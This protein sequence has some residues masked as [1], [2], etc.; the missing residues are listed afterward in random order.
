[1]TVD[2]KPLEHPWPFPITHEASGAVP[3]PLSTPWPACQA[4]GHR[5]WGSKD[6]HT[7]AMSLELS[8][9]LAGR[10]EDCCRWDL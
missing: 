6:V 2:A 3:S 1:M 5:V 9:M 8:F 4:W 10:G 7:E